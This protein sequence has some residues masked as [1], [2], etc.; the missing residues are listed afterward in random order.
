MSAPLNVWRVTVG[1]VIRDTTTGKRYAVV[2]IT[3]AGAAGTRHSDGPVIHARIVRDD[4]TTNPR[5]FV[6][7]IWQGSAVYP[8]DRF[9]PTT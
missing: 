2:R 5:G 9:T 1:D 7:D 8:A 6:A 3:P 4:G